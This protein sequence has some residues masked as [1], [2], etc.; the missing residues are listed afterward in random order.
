MHSI[1]HS[2]HLFTGK[3]QQLTPLKGSF[4]SLGLREAT[5][6]AVVA[7][8]AAAAAC[9][10]ASYACCL[11]AIGKACVCVCVCVCACV[12]LCVRVRVCVCMCVCVSACACVCVCVQVISAAALLLHESMLASLSQHNL[13]KMQCQLHPATKASCSSLFR[14]SLGP[15]RSCLLQASRPHN[16]R[17]SGG[18]P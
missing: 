13:H 10:C 2:K 11:C 5:P 9:V 16:G 4:A 14:L 15:D 6:L 8:T 17:W 7:V 18:A 1:L 3:F 12:C